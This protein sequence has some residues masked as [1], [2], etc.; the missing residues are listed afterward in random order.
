ME[1]MDLL[2]VLASNSFTSIEYWE[3]KTFLALKS[4]NDLMSR[5]G[6]DDGG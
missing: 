6:A 5:K 1:V 2:L 3:R 4:W